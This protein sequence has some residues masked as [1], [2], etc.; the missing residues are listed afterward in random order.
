MYQTAGFLPRD[1][2]LLDDQMLFKTAWHII[3]QYGHNFW[4]TIL[5]FHQY[6]SESVSMCVYTHCRVTYTFS[7]EV[8]KGLNNTMLR[9]KKFK[10]I[11]LWTFISSKFNKLH[12]H[13][14]PVLPHL[15][16]TTSFPWHLWHHWI[17]FIQKFESLKYRK[18]TIQ[19]PYIYNHQYVLIVTYKHKT[20]DEQIWYMPIIEKNIF[21]LL[22]DGVRIYSMLRIKHFLHY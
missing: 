22:P 20:Q 17:T 11:L 15:F 2:S 3:W 1:H 7:E 9:S 13:Y 19:C 16:I 12:Q 4:D 14:K 18:Q 6:A 8:F 5:L 21:L 10:N